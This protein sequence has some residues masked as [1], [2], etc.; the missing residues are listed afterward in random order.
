MQKSPTPL[1]LYLIRH[2][3]TEWALTG[4]HT[5]A[6]DI[7]LTANGEDEELEQFLRGCGWTPYFVEGDNPMDMH[8]LMAATLD[9]AI[10]DI[11]Q[12]QKT[13]RSDND[14]T[15][16]LSGHGGTFHAAVRH[17]AGT[18]SVAA[19]TALGR[20]QSAGEHAGLRLNVMNI[21][22]KSQLPWALS[23]SFGRA[24]QQPALE[25]WQGEAGRVPAAQKALYHRTGCNRMARRGEYT[26][27]IEGV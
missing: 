7:A 6:K 19:A 25:N 2:G 20:F 14:T 16:H 22:F 12:I 1:H 11:R 8:Q 18:C 5:G 17:A 27:E 26:A 10:E 23:F 21:R 9:R 4:Q 13:A 15:R 3:E 24:I